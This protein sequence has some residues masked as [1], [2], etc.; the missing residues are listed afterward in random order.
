M[1]VRS[2]LGP[3]AGMDEG[4]KHGPDIA[5]KARGVN[6]KALAQH[7]R[8]EELIKVCPHLEEPHKIL[9][10]LEGLTTFDHDRIKG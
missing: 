2:H 4:G 1:D 9:C 5:E 7:L 3:C 6:D 8:E 10:H